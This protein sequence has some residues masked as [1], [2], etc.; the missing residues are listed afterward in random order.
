MSNNDATTVRLDANVIAEIDAII[1]WL[2]PT[3]VNKLTRTA[4]VRRA[5]HDFF[6]R[7]RPTDNKIVLPVVSQV[8]E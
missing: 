8:Q 2:P 1:G 3:D 6:L 7:T 4:V 5:V